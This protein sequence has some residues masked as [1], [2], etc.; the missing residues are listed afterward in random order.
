VPAHL[1]ILPCTNDLTSLVASVLCL[2]DGRSFREVH[3]EV[4][5]APAQESGGERSVWGFNS[6][7]AMPLTDKQGT[8]LGRYLP[9]RAVTLVE[10]Q[11]ALEEMTRVIASWR[12]YSDTAKQRQEDYGEIWAKARDS[13]GSAE[14]VL[15]K[16]R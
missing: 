2:N 3:A 4:V 11:C 1:A 6:F 13:G 14:S 12:S 8:N 5:R 10:L 15:R 7:S 16:P 9:G